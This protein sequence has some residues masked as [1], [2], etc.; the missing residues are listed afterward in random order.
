MAATW[1]LCI[2]F[3]Q[4]TATGNCKKLHKLHLMSETFLHFA[5]CLKRKKL[6]SRQLF[7]LKH[8]NAPRKIPEN[9]K[10]FAEATIK[11]V[12]SPSQLNSFSF[13]RPVSSSLTVSSISMLSVFVSHIRGLTLNDEE[14]IEMTPYVRSTSLGLRFG[15]IDSSSS[16]KL[17]IHQIVI[18]RIQ[19]EMLMEVRAR[20]KYFDDILSVA[21]HTRSNSTHTLPVHM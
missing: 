21:Y 1:H 20:F 6:N 9:R 3:A 17:L 16:I 14:N 12:V 10:M 11:N 18:V 5:G 19:M 15:S 7:V 13:F 4:T 8:S 2:V